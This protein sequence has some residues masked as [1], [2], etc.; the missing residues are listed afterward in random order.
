MERLPG[1][2]TSDA[3]PHARPEQD[4]LRV[5]A[6]LRDWIFELAL[7]FWSTV[8]MNPPAAAGRGRGAAE[9][10]TLAGVPGEPGFR[11]MRVQARQLYVFAEAAARGYAGAAAIA[12]GIHRFMTR[13]GAA[14][15]GGWARLL[16]P[17][18]QVLD[19]TNDL[20]DLAFVLFGLA[21]YARLTGAPAP[22]AQA[23]RTLG[24]LRRSMSRP[25]GG[26]ANAWPP[27]PGWRQQ[28]PHM[29]LLEAALELFDVSRDQRWADLA[30]DLVVLF[31]EHLLEPGSDTLGEYFQED[32]RRAAGLEGDKVE[33]GHH[34][35]WVWLL[36][37]HEA[38]T[39]TATGDLVRRLDGVA[40]RH[41]VG[42]ATGLVRDEI[43]RDGS[44]R[45][46][47]SRLWVQT[48]MLRA[49]CVMH[50]RAVRAAD[51]EAADA[52][53][54]A[55]VVTTDNLL[56]RYLVGRDAAVLPSGTWIDQLDAFARPAIDRIPTSSFY[57]IMA[58]WVELD[59][60]VAR[61]LGPAAPAG[62]GQRPVLT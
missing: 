24:F 12:D 9:F 57:H 27:E 36:D 61:G 38:L 54:R 32:W 3:D 48:E 46:G 10:V 4:I 31:R 44:L 56:S 8:G 62:P 19:P 58:A 23:A 16:D 30:G 35:E 53:L 59:R 39:G 33:P 50:A 41:G 22:L 47:S 18:G 7:P 42:P 26:F 13:H 6:G 37:R 1:I 28:N 40:M 43:G 55:I 60:L 2:A 29:H 52:R 49:H 45:R 15:D 51:P 5:H 20:Y 17:D 11:R 21:R 14:A 34:A 25:S